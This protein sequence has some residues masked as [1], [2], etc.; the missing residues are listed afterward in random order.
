MP[1][2]PYYG[3]DETAAF[4]NVPERRGRKRRPG[5]LLVLAALGLVAA[6]LVAFRPWPREARSTDAARLPRNID[7]T[8]SCGPVALAAVSQ[9][10]GRPGSI[11]D[12]HRSTGAGNLGVCSLDD[13]GRALERHGLASVALRY[14]NN[15]APCHRLPMILFVDGNHFI[16]VVSAI[17]PATVVVIDPPEEPRLTSWAD[18][19]SRWGGEALLVGRTES[20]INL[21]LNR[22]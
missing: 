10:L 9:R 18:L 4:K 6:A 20:E 5:Y 21:A 12:F 15:R 19:R 3:S 16:T 17:D 11:A 2:S 22:E 7:P 14:R 8:T 13:T 1:H